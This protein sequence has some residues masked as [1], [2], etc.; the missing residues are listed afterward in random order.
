MKNELILKLI[1]E[2]KIDELKQK[3]L[4]E[5]TCQ[6][7]IN[8]NVTKAIIKLSKLAEKESRKARP[9]L[10]GAWINEDG[11]QCICN[12]FWAVKYNQE[13]LGTINVQEVGDYFQIDRVFPSDPKENEFELDLNEINNKLKIA[14]S[15]SIKKEIHLVK[16]KGIYFNAEYIVN[17]VSSFENPKCYV[18]NNMLYVKGLNGKGLILP[19]RC[20]D[21]AI[22]ICYYN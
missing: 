1:N 10:A 8:K 13:T 17:V 2:N 6:T 15:D 21:S 19:V 5:L 11:C 22:A 3:V 12:G 4:E 16:L 20:T 9:M 18:T 14:K 7:S